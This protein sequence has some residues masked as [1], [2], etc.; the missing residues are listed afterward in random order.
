MHLYCLMT[1]KPPFSREGLDWGDL[2]KKIEAGDFPPPR[3]VRAD[4][5]R[6][7]EAICL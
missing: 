4:L 6:P 5:D 3:Q 7:R 2:I 1:G